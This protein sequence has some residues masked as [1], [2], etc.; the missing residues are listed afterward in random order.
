MENP[1]NSQNFSFS[2]PVLPVF[3]GFFPGKKPR[4]RKEQ[5]PVIHEMHPKPQNPGNK[6]RIQAFLHLF[7]GIPI[8]NPPAP[9]TVIDQLSIPD[10]PA[11]IS[12][13]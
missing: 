9:D 6:R 5:I 7:I 2:S 1:Q 10:P 8:P 4:Q 3:L 13:V 11:G 12:E